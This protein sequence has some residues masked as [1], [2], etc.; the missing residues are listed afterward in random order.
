MIELCL[1]IQKYQFNA[2]HTWSK[3]ISY[4]SHRKALPLNIQKDTQ[5]TLFSTTVHL[6]ANRF[7]EDTR[8]QRQEA[9]RRRV[10][11]SIPHL[12]VITRNGGLWRIQDARPG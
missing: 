3:Y 6:E 7:L 9:F 11:N 1:F 8:C 10:G 2:S 12:A 4:S 5:K